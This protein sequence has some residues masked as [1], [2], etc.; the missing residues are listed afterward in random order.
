MS[1][2]VKTYDQRNNAHRPKGPW[3]NR[4]FIGMLTFCFGLLT[5]I[6]EGFVLRDIET[7]RPP[8]WEAYRS[9]RSDQSLSELQVRSSELGRQLADLDRQIKRQEAEQRVLQDGSRNLQ[10]TMRQLVEL[11]RLSIQKEVAMSEGDQANLSTAL[12]QFLETQTRYQS[13]NKQLQDQHETKR[14]AEDEK[15]SVD[16][17]VQ[18]ATAPIRREYDQEIRQFRMRLALYQLLVL[19]PLLLA[20]GTL[21]LKRPQSGYYPVFLAFGLA[22]LFKCYLVVDRYFPARYVNYVLILLLLAVVGKLLMYSIGLVMSPGRKWLIKQYREAYERFLCPVCEYPIRTGPRRFL[23]WTRRTVHK[24][25]PPQASSGQP[26]QDEPYSCPSCGTT[27]FEDCRQC[28]HSRHSLLPHC[29]HCG[30]GS[31]DEVVK[32]DLKG[33]ET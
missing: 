4:V 16:D 11:Q 10:E 1:A 29:S 31:E 9:Q 27:L 32:H 33:T 30:E 15:R 13:F 25:I 26:L 18:Q 3:L 20:S 17:Q 5:F 7:I 28:G 19:I 23:Y 12:N 21:L 22:T 8:D 24:T 2:K 14:L 6:F